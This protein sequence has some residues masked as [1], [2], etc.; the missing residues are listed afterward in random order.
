[1]TETQIKLA[2]MAAL[3]QLG[4]LREM[5][6]AG[7]SQIIDGTD[8][9][10]VNAHSIVANNAVVINACTGLDNATPRNAVDFKTTYNWV[11]LPAGTFMKVP[12]GF[13]ITSIDLTSGSLS[14]YNY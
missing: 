2:M 6:G 4:D 14:V 3:E 12:K 13:K 11:T 1:M 5:S 7:G 9:T 10:A 8:V